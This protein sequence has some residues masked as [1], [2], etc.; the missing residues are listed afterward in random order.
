M[1]FQTP[2]TLLKDQAYQ[3]HLS[4]AAPGYRINAAQDYGKLGYS[5]VN[6]W[7]SSIADFSM[8]HGATW[9]GWTI[10]SWNTTQYRKDMWMHMALRVM[11]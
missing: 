4:S 6:R 8:D 10:R 7:P 11:A 3:I 9:Y 1:K 2:I 5:S